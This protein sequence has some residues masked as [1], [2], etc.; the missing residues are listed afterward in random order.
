MTFGISISVENSIADKFQRLAHYP[1]GF[2]EDI[3]RFWGHQILIDLGLTLLPR[4]GEDPSF[5][6]ATENEEFDVLENDARLMLEHVDEI[7]VM[8]HKDKALII[9]YIDNLRRAI[10]LAKESGSSIVIIYTF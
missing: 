10:Q 9:V 8:T 2:N 4:L 7:S 6:Q 5:L 1:L 3:T